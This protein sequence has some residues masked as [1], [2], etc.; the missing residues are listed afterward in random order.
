[1]E[2]Q[3]PRTIREHEEDAFGDALGQRQPNEVY[4]PLE[5]GNEPLERW[6]RANQSEKRG[7]QGENEPSRFSDDST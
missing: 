3:D 1:M 7:T 4:V 2:H 6:R 5:E